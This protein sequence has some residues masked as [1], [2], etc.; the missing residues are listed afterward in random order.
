MFSVVFIQQTTAT[1][2]LFDSSTIIKLYK[3]LISYLSNELSEPAK[4]F[5]MPRIVLKVDLG[6][7]FLIHDNYWTKMAAIF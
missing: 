4:N 7:H 6:L 1:N 2:Y 5:F 3:V